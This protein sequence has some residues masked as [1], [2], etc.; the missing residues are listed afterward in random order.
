[1]M[2]SSPPT[3]KKEIVK[4]AETARETCWPVQRTRTIL[5]LPRL[6]SAEERLHKSDVFGRTPG[7]KR[8]LCESNYV[9]ETLLLVRRRHVLEVGV[10]DHGWNVSLA[11]L[12]FVLWSHSSEGVQV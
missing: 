12:L 7:R 3:P 9:I 11:P 8:C 1:M 4:S 5:C 2:C 6:A 10:D